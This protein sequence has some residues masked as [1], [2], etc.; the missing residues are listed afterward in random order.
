MARRGTLGRMATPGAPSHVGSRRLVLVALS[1]AAVVV[2]ALAIRFGALDIVRP[3][4]PLSGEP[5][6]LAGRQLWGSCAGGFYARRGADVVLTSSAHCA[7]EG[8]T[9][10][11]PDGRTVRGV[12]GPGAVLAACEHTEHTC[13]PSDMNYV[14]V[15]TTRSRGAGST[16]LTWV[17]AALPNRPRYGAAVVHRHRSRQQGRVINGRDI[18][19]SGSVAENSASTST[20]RPQMATTFRASSPRPTSRWESVIWAVPRSSMV[21]RPG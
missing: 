20:T 7:S 10:L 18:F 19:R 1:L 9:A 12:F 21:C 13:R 6:V 3:R 5:P 4:P 15:A 14:V 16:P 2:A 17:T 8:A 11:A